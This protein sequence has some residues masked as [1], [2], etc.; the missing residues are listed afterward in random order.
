M[1]E[2]QKANS[3]THQQKLISDSVSEQPGPSQSQSSQFRTPRVPR[4]KGSSSRR[5]PGPFRKRVGKNNSR[6]MGPFCRKARLQDSFRQETDPFPISTVLQTVRKSCFRR[7]GPEAPP[8][9]GSGEHKP[10]RSRF[11]LPNIPS[12][13]KEGKVKTYKS[14][15]NKFLNVQSFSMETANK[16]RNTIY[17]K[18]WAIS[19]DLTDAYLHVPIHVTSRKYL[20]FCLK[21]RVFQ[22]R[23]FLF[24]LATSP[25]VFTRLMVAIAAHLR[26]RAIILFSYLDDWLVRNQCRLGLIKDKELTLRLMT[27]LGLIINR[28]KS[29]LIPSQN[30]IFRGMEFVTQDNIVRVPW[31]RVQDIL[32][33]VSWF[34]KQVAVTARMFL[35]LLGKLSASVQF[36]VLGRLH[37]RPLQM[38]LFAQW[39]PHILP[40]EHKIFVTEQIKHHLGRWLDRD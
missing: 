31:D 11:L 38:A 37:L 39:K 14:T 19:L 32:C 5:T 28:E 13:E 25:F 24:G 18:D 27:S 12:S 16:V 3:E 6:Q 26:V 10:G 35:S 22:I 2:I 29:E 20:R 15:L 34:Q 1:A 33:L 23:T 9:E 36:V 40:L 8:K 30:F 4:K 7:R 17:P 21:G